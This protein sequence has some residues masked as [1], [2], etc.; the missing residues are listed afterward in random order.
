MSIFA[1]VN[2]RISENLERH[3]HFL[4][5]PHAPDELRIEDAVDLLIP[6][7]RPDR[8]QAVKRS[9]VAL[10]HENMRRPASVGLPP[11]EPEQG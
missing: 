1:D 11:E 2:R 3:G 9:I 8:R 7:V 6:L 10:I 4:T 5:D